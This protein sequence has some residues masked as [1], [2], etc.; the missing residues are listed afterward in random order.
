LI[1]AFVFSFLISGDA[2][3]LKEKRKLTVMPDI[4]LFSVFDSKYQKTFS[5]F[6]EDNF[7]FRDD[8]LKI[9]II[10]NSLKGLSANEGKLYTIG[11]TER[12][13]KKDKIKFSKWVKKEQ[14]TTDSSR[15]IIDDDGVM[16]NNLLIYNKRAY[17]LF[18]GCDAVAKI[19]A[20]SVNDLKKALGDSITLYNLLI[21]SPAEFYLPIRYKTLKSSEKH[22][23]D[24]VKSNLNSKIIDVNAYEEISRHTD[25]Y[26]YFATD[27]HWTVHGAYCAYKAFAKS[28]KFSPISTDVLTM[29]TK[30][31][32][33]GSLYL[34]T[35]DASLASNPDS[36]S[37]Y[38]IPGNYSVFWDTCSVPPRWYPS[39]LIVDCPGCWA[40]YGVFLGEDFAVMK[41][42]TNNF[43]NRRILVLKESFGNAFIPFLVPHYEKVFVADIRYFKYSLLKFIKEYKINE[44]LVIMSDISANNTYF[45][46]KLR[47]MPYSGYSLHYGSNK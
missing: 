12:I 9:P 7:P 40:N 3:S 47:T 8:W 26:L 1:S 14:T 45:G 11:I 2:I 19:Y 35:L 18:G 36:V 44:V 38:K 30:K 42:E 10:I 29:V 15:I 21:P 17:Q 43:N 41:I 37:Y 32:Y 34:L 23:L 22:N 5:M 27:H 13:P 6:Y 46:Y 33:L 28:A 31:N 20:E 24:I 39:S 16:V 25:E 4:S